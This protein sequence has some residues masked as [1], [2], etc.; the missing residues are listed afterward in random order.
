MLFQG[1]FGDMDIHLSEEYGVEIEAFV[2]FGSIE[3]G[4]HRDTGMMNR[5]NWK[6]ANYDTCEHKVKFNVSYLM[7][8]LDVR[9]S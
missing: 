4:T 3:F 1:I 2:L 5:L 8:D 7:G 6:S 9:V